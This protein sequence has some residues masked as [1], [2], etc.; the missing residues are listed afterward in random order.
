MRYSR[1][2]LPAVLPSLGQFGAGAG[3][4]VSAVPLVGGHRGAEQ[5]ERQTRLSAPRAADQPATEEK[6]IRGEE[7]GR[8]GNTSLQHINIQRLTAE[9]PNA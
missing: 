4:G 2:R 9:T 5:S 6:G 7:E 8:T 1:S 3:R